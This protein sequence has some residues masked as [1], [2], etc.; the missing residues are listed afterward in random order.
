[1][2]LSS[3]HSSLTRL[4]AIDAPRCQALDQ[5]LTKVKELMGVAKEKMA[6][7]LEKLHKKKAEEPKSE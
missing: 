4:R 2:E 7:L 1:M 6:P 3:Q 5:A